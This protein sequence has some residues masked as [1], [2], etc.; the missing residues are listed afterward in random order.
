MM[1]GSGPKRRVRIG[2]IVFGALAAAKVAEF[3]VIKA[4]PKGAWP[5]LAVLALVGAWLIYYYFMH[6]RALWRE[7]KDDD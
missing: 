7:R 4:F 6:I 3:A 1:L 5:Y 2:Y